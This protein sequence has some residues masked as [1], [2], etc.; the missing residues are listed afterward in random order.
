VTIVDIQIAIIEFPG[1]NCERESAEAIRRNGMQ[2][3][4]FRWNMPTDVLRSCDG[5]LIAGGFSYEDRS[6]SGV[7]AAMDPILDIL[8]QESATGKPILGICNG[9]QVLVESGLVPGLRN[10]QLGCALTENERTIEGSSPGSGFY[11]TWIDLTYTPGPKPL[12]TAFT[13]GMDPM[14]TFR[15][16]AAHAEGRFVIPQ[17]LLNSMDD[18]GMTVFRYAHNPNGSVSDL[19]GICN[20]C[21]N[22]L[23]LMPHPERTPQGDPI[24]RSMRE[25]ILQEKA[26][27]WKRNCTADRE[28]PLD[29]QDLLSI[30]SI[31][32][33]RV[34]DPKISRELII[35]TIIT[36]NSAVSVEQALRR[37]G[38]PVRIHRAIH[39]E[40]TAQKELPPREY[41]QVIQKACESGE[42]F[43][44]NKEFIGTIPVAPL[45]KSYLTRQ[46]DEH[47]TRGQH[48]LHAL[49]HWFG[50]SAI[51]SI[52]YGILWTILPETDD[53][54][55]SSAIID[56]VL[57]T[58][59]IANPY[60]QKRY[61]YA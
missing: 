32:A 61:L 46:Q 43:N 60:S 51:A 41:D 30:D 24:F 35:D 25:Y 4:H 7:I 2:S 44:S 17:S 13:L 58:N 19:A 18:S 9:A 5:Y 48:A 16:P 42:L 57:R 53:P 15:I 10:F 31:P 47:D 59:I 39:W 8:K 22:I 38:L 56:A 45:S 36:D 26:H 20:A 50:I 49:S 34:E 28:I 6:R 11:N 1:T 33:Y 37:A 23:A 52:R 3:I 27:G 55:E 40:I 29:M 12:N 21:G 54:K 14:T